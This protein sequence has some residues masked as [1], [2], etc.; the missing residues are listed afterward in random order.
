MSSLERRS[1]LEASGDFILEASYGSHRRR[2]R[3]SPRALAAV[4]ALGACAAGTLLCA[5]GYLAFH[6]ELVAGLMARQ[7]RMQQ[8]YEDRVAA[9]RLR[10]DQ[11]ASRQVVDRD[12][13]EG[14][15]HR[16]VLR[17]AQL[18]T[19]AA[20]VARLVEGA[21]SRDS[22]VTVI[23]PAAR[24]EARAAETSPNAAA[25]L[26]NARNAA[27]PASFGA[28]EPEGLELRLGDESKP[29]P[30]PS[31]SAEPGGQGSTPAKT[32]SLAP[33]RLSG[34]AD[35]AEAPLP[36]RLERLAAA[37]DR[38]EREQTN[39]L[40]RVLRPAMAA[41]ARLRE[42]FDV[43]G[44]SPARFGPGDAAAKAR[45]GEAAPVGGP[46]VA[47]PAAGGG[48]LFDRQ[49]AAAQS[50]VARLDELRRALP[51]APLRKPL[52]GPL[53]MTSAFGYRADP[54]LGRP[55]LHSGVDLRDE[56][57]AS[58]RA[59]AAGIV[60]TA[61][62]Q[63][64]YGNLVEIDHGG[65]VSTRYGHLSAIDVAPGQQVG[66]GAPIGRVG[67]TGRSTGPHLHYEV[68]VDGEAVDP[69]RFLRAASTLS[70]AAL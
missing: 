22:G 2:F 36:A 37:L 3:F 1:S 15:V 69:A 10:L 11:L 57:G 9:L 45:R 20:V 26:K 53:Q 40:A 56:F 39:R 58:V 61:S 32:S 34:P 65:G 64:G 23:A 62:P 49:L 52:A 19:R 30:L 48:S 42:A 41:E 59:T 8:A 55:A 18:E 67:A 25:T 13:V 63:G 44:L 28:P 33:E 70:D 16:L 68:R 47:A 5:A 50:A 7:M 27:P 46:F 17:Q 51:M 43:A 31:P 54:F 35:A 66:P 21:L 24:A 4:A 6:D 12:G 60:T 14:K 29:A 38:A